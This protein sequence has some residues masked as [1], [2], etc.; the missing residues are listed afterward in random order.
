MYYSGSAWTWDDYVCWSLLG[1]STRRY[2]TSRSTVRQRTG[3]RRVAV[4]SRTPWWLVKTQRRSDYPFTL[5][6][7]LE[8][9]HGAVQQEGPLDIPLDTNTANP[10]R[11]EGKKR[12]K[13]RN[14]NEPRTRHRRRHRAT[15]QPNNARLHTQQVGV[16]EHPSEPNEPTKR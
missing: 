13:R 8:P 6:S 9:V 5:T 4:Y 16:Y 2:D 7:Y 10:V 12:R 15:R 14:F 11:N 1:L 3:R